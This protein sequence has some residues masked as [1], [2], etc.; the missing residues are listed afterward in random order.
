MHTQ[1]APVAGLDREHAVG[2]DLVERISN[3][4]TDRLVVA[5][6]DGRNVLRGGEEG[7][8]FAGEGGR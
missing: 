2:A 4:L 5:G 1:C 3:H 6:R 8:W 7:W